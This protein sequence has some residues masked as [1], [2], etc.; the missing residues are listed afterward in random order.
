M[1]KIIVDLIPGVRFQSDQYLD[2][3]KKQSNI[4]IRVFSSSPKSKFKNLESNKYFFSPLIFKIITRLIKIKYYSIFKIFDFFIFSFSQFIY[5]FVFRKSNVTHGFIQFSLIRFIL[6]KR[7]FKILDAPDPP[8]TIVNKFIS[9]ENFKIKF[10]DK[11][12][13]NIE[14]LE[15][16]KSDMVLVPSRFTYNAFIKYG[17]DRNKIVYQP[18]FSNYE[19]KNCYKQKNKKKM[20][21]GFFGGNIRRKGLDILINQWI[22]CDVKEYNLWIKTS[23]TELK[24]YPSIYK[25]INKLKNV[26]IFTEYTETL[27]DFYN[28]IDLMIHPA[29]SDGYGM[30]NLQAMLHGIPCAVSTHTGFSDF[31]NNSN[32]FK[33]D[34]KS[35]KWLEN[36]LK[37]SSKEKFESLNKSIMENIT[38]LKKIKSQQKETLLNAYKKDIK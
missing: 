31:I 14:K 7:S 24:K 9:N 1:K 33:F 10:I 38:E 25:K 12:F 3:L 8:L 17:V 35:D 11:F 15:I 19:A 32:G 27:E 34:P 29:I 6:N 37:N 23:K 36:L 21:F 5:H 13:E 20:I 26:K 4:K 16:Q 28:S 18:L 2:S 22:K 30:T